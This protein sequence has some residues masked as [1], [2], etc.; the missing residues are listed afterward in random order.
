M[1]IS[2][3]EKLKVHITDD[4]NKDTPLRKYMK[5]VLNVTLSPRTKYTYINYLPGRS[6]DLPMLCDFGKTLNANY[7]K[8][9]IVE[10]L[11]VL[12]GLKLVEA[13]LVIETTD[14]Q[15]KT[16]QLAKEDITDDES[17]LYK[18]SIKGCKEYTEKSAQ[19]CT[20]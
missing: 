11:K 5:G 18:L 10:G 3:S 15:I 6:V 7:K 1:L 8:S 12:V 16:E 17:I 19:D 20:K 13:F 2:D 9:G 14:G 4:N